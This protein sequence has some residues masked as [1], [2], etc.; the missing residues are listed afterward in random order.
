MMNFL[1]VFAVI[2]ALFTLAGCGE[3]VAVPPASKGV[4]LTKDGLR[5]DLIPPSQFRLSPCY[6]P[7]SICDKLV[8]IQAGDVAITESVDVLM[9]KDNL[10]MGVDVRFTTGLSDSDSEILNV[11]NRVQPMQS[12]SRSILLTQLD[13]VYKIYGEPIIQNVVRS[14]LSRYTIQE[15]AA[16]QSEISEVLKQEVT[17]ALKRTP[18][19]ISQFGLASIRYPEPILAAMNNAATRKV[20]I[21][22]VESDYQIKLRE[23]Q[24]NYEVSKQQRE[25]DLLT[26]QTLRD[27]DEILSNGIT[28]EILRYREIQAIEKMSENKNAVFFPYSMSESV[29][30]QNRMFN[31]KVGD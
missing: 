17:E 11:F 3:L 30:L 18:L 10:I 5:G 19:K 27:A 26:A 6:I 23:A 24:T 29:G 8:V 12:D 15:L 14:T 28:P 21:E 7:G 25:V 16:N 9:P 20:E 31:T 22:K 1:K 4:I 13:S 2:G